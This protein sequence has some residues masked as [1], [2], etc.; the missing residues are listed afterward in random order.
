[1]ENGKVLVEQMVERL[2]RL[3]REDLVG[4]IEESDEK[5][6][7]FSIPGGKKLQITVEEIA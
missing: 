3:I 7:V 4:V 1:M 6:I 2:K 5:S